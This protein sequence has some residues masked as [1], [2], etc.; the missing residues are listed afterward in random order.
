MAP[1][2]RAR[3]ASCS[4]A[5]VPLRA[6]ERPHHHEGDDEERDGEQPD[7][8]HRPP[9]GDDLVE[10][11]VEDRVGVVLDPVDA[12]GRGQQAQRCAEAEGQRAQEGAAAPAGA[13]RPHERHEAVQPRQADAEHDRAVEVGPQHQDREDEVRPPARRPVVR[14]Q[15]PQQHH[16]QRIGEAL[17]ADLDRDDHVEEARG[18]QDPE[19]VLLR[20]PERQRRRHG[21]RERAHGEQRVAEGDERKAP[22]RPEAVHRQLGQPLLVDPLRAERQ[23]RQRV[24]VRDPVVG[25]LAPRDQSE[26]AVLMDVAPGEQ[27]HDDARGGDAGD[28]ERVALEPVGNALQDRPPLHDPHPSQ[29]DLT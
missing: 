2:M 9:L 18:R 21:D 26:P 14:G 23:R 29:E 8:G 6:R 25:D 17:R 24:V 22:E 20:A 12:V 19:H 10:A 27:E 4:K 5:L 11:R 16:E 7:R 3:S 13:Q 28:E 15:Q 1:A